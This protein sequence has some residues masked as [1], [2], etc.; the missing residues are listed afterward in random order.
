MPKPVLALLALLAGG[1]THAAPVLRIVVGNAEPAPSST[2]PRPG[3]PAP[4]SN[5]SKPRRSA[6]A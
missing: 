3:C 2:T 6:A 4:S 1:W 5:W